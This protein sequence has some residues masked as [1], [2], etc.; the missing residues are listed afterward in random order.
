MFTKVILLL[1]LFSIVF[2]LSEILVNS[3]DPNFSSLSLRCFYEL[4]KIWDKLDDVNIT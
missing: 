2:V 1:N 4:T 3:E